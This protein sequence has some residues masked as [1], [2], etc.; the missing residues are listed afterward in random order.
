MTVNDFSIEFDLLFNNIASNKAPG[1]N[2]YEKSLFLTQAQEILVRGLYS[3]GEQSFESTEE[4]TS[5]LAS[6]TKRLTFDSFAR[7]SVYGWVTFDVVI[8]D[9]VW[10]ITLES[11]I[12]G[13]KPV[14]VIPVR[15]DMFLRTV[16]NPFRGPTQKRTIRLTSSDKTSRVSSLI[17]S[18]GASMESYDI[19]YVEKPSPVIL[20][21]G[22]EIDGVEYNRQTSMLPENMHRMLLMKAVELAKSAWV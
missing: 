11:G 22:I 10:Y 7:G 3:S 21:D 18:K 9:S 20:E 8:P 17:P 6:I 1:L 15:Q 12:A 4:M 5:Y 13:G 14:E 16:R 2:E 19:R